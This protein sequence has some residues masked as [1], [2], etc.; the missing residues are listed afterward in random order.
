MGS[1]FKKILDFPF[2]FAKGKKSRQ[3]EI[4]EWPKKGLPLIIQQLMVMSEVWIQPIQK[5]SA[6]Q[7]LGQSE[8]HNYSTG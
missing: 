4:P 6:R 5:T 2:F 8:Y 7:R 1:D 3:G